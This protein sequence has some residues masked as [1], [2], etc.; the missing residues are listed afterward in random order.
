MQKENLF[1]G[2]NNFHVKIL[3]PRLK[4]LQVTALDMGFPV[5]KNLLVNVEPEIKLPASAGSW[6]KQEEFQRNIYFCFIDYAKVF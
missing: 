6:K 5:I 3:T 2:L 1:D 4:S